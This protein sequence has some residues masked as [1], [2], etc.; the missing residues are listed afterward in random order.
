MKVH[1][2][3]L[4][5]TFLTICSTETANGTVLSSECKNKYEV[6]CWNN[7]RSINLLVEKLGHP[8]ANFWK[9]YPLTDINTLPSDSYFDA[10]IYGEGKTVGFKGIFHVSCP[11]ESPGEWEVRSN[12]GLYDDINIDKNTLEQVVS[13]LTSYVCIQ[14]SPPESNA[15]TSKAIPK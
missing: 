14:A 4:I 7:D 8:Y 13:N 3:T 6:G 2:Y 12:W 15:K 10:V 9:A 11:G 5:V 1:V